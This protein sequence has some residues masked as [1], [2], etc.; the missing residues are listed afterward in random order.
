MENFS[1]FRQKLFGEVVITA[2]FVSIRTYWGKTKNG[3]SEKSISFLSFLETARKVSAGWSTLH[4]PRQKDLYADQF[5]ELYVSLNFLYTEGNFF[6]LSSK[7]LRRSC[8][9]CILRVHQNVLRKNKKRIFRKK[10][11]FFYHS[12]RLQGNFRQG[13]Q[14]CIYRDNRIFMQINFLNYMLH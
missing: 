2:F 11:K 13:G 14:H 7:T 8:N 6:G 9:H 4:L 10:Y 12:W 3:S 1:A 5:F